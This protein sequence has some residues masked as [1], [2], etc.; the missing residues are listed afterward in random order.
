MLQDTQ[1]WK[2]VFLI[3]ACVHIFG[4]TFYAIFCSGELQPW[5]DPSMEEQKNFAMDEFGQAKPPIPPPP[6]TM[7]SE[8]IVCIIFFMLSIIICENIN[9]YLTTIIDKI[10]LFIF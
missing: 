2:N 5:A 8:F 7:Q 1:S 4:V 10:E 3:A 9:E 6:S